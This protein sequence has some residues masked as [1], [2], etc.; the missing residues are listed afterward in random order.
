MAAMH[1]LI[2][3]ASVLSEAGRHALTTLQLP[4]LEAL[5]AR[6]V[7][8]DRDTG[9]E[10]ALSPPHERCLA[11]ELGFRGA[12]GALPWAAHQAALDG[13]DTA[14]TA[15]GLV[16]PTYWHVGAEQV[17]LADPA[18]LELGEDDSRALL[19]AVRDIFE[20]E[21]WTVRYGGA[22]RWYVAHDSLEGMACASL[23]RVVGRGVDL[24]LRE[25][26]AVHADDPRQ[27]RLR[28]LQNEVQMRLH[29]H[30]INERRESQGLPA[31]N[32]FW[33]SGCG[34]AQRP[35]DVEGLVV[36]ETLRAAALQE[37]WP[38]WADAWRALDAGAVD[39]AL[40]EAHA[41]RDVTL[42]LCGE[43][44]AQRFEPGGSPWARWMR[45][46]RRASPRAALEAL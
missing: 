42:T 10:Y 38:G 32:S 14:G 31:V 9:D 2:P 6:L 5:V 16:T 36:E 3:H 8:G 44:H 21:G 28:R 1:L 45:S 4:K 24:W 12:D 29:E 30:A 7:P 22:L 25:L 19:E 18:T 11:R 35:R 37:D 20:G 41:G 26:P 46:L 34:R 33:L 43:R 17:T 40:R 13:I 23:D 39:E 27:R 15:W